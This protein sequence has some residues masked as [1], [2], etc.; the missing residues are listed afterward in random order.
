MLIIAMVALVALA[1]LGGFTALSVQG[2]VS[3]QS[4]A[5]FNSI[6]L[7]AAESGVASAMKFLREN[8][9]PVR[10]WS[11]YVTRNNV[12]PLK[13]LEIEGNLVV[14]GTAGNLFFR[15]LPDVNDEY[16]AWFSVTI[17]NNEADPAFGLD[18]ASTPLGLDTD[19][20]LTLRVVGFGPNGARVTLIVDVTA[21]NADALTGR[22]CSYNAQKGLSAQND[23]VGCINSDID[24]S[25][26]G[27]FNAP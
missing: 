24:T 15:N 4:T 1:G 27:V 2:G 18:P 14:P 25:G 13:P 20:R 3:A 9:D 22:P 19:A 26:G 17:L 10:N 16:P 12:S 8:I 7:Y 21:N 23:G 5:R 6:G 11:A